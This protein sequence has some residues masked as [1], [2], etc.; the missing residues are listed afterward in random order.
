MT[1]YAY[2]DQI[3]GMVFFLCATFLTGLSALCLHTCNDFLMSVI[4]N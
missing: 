3:T 4:A 2:T 1:I